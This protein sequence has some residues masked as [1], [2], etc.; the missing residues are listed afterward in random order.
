[1]SHRRPPRREPPR[2]GRAGFLHPAPVFDR[3]RPDVEVQ[4]RSKAREERG[5]R[6]GRDIWTHQP[7][8]FQ[9]PR[10]FFLESYT[11][12][13]TIVTLA[14]T[15]RTTSAP[16]RSRARCHV[17]REAR[18]WDGPRATCSRHADR[19]GPRVQAALLWNVAKAAETFLETS[20]ADLSIYAERRRDLLTAIARLG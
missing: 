8:A 5:G 2:R 14:P 19:K 11:A 12:R 13:F 7:L 16:W 10:S 17:C 4:S 1:M 9:P 3:D 15:N 18:D 20:I 6:R